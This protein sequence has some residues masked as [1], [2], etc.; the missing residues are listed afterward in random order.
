MCNHI[1][2]FYHTIKHLEKKDFAKHAKSVWF[3]FLIFFLAKKE[4]HSVEEYYYQIDFGTLWRN[5]AKF[6][7]E[8]K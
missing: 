7:A 6:R 8:N 2:N 3:D 1:N 4:Y 5:L